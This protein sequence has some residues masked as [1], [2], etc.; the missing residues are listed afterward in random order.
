MS[1]ADRIVPAC[2]EL[3]Q[4][5]TAAGVPATL[6]RS[7]LRVPGAWISPATANGKTLDG[8]GRANVDVLLV[9]PAQADEEALGDLQ[10]LLSKAI[11]VVRPA[12]GTDVDTSVIFP[13]NN[14]ALPAFRLVVALSL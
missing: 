5:L 2:K 9:V 13:H 4:V 6:S 14:N 10:D 1:W 12:P 11:S 8:T 7:S 3:Q